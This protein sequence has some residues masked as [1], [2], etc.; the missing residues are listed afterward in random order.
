MAVAQQQR[1]GLSYTARVDKE[2]LESALAKGLSQRQIADRHGC[3]QVNVRYWLKKHGLQSRRRV[4]AAPKTATSVRPP[5]AFPSRPTA[6]TANDSNAVAAI[7][8]SRVLAALTNAGYPCYV[9]FGVGKA[10]LVIETGDGMKSVQCKTARLVRNGSV[11]EFATTSK[12]YAQ[13]RTT[14][15]GLVDYFGVAVPGRPGV[16]LVPVSEVGK[17]SAY[18]RVAPPVNGQRSLVRMADDFLI[19]GSTEI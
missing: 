5:I 19:P 2:L 12:N 1:T 17:S 9:P 15:V 7:V 10:D 4:A 3:S 11:I 16:Y 8:E 14:Y 13:Q 18:L 6:L